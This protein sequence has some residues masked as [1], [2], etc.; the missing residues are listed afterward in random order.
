MQISITDTA[1]S[2][3]QQILHFSFQYF[4]Q[5][6]EFQ[7]GKLRLDQVADS[8]SNHLP[9]DFTGGHY[10]VAYLSARLM[11][12]LPF[13]LGLSDVLQIKNKSKQNWVCRAD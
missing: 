3:H 7:I 9:K 4:S 13:S 6:F 12:F 11:M 5:T 2:R 1:T 10:H 8:S